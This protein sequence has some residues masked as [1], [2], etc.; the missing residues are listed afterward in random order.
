VGRHWGCDRC[1]WR[2][3][4]FDKISF[5]TDLLLD[6]IRDLEHSGP[7]GSPA[8]HKQLG[9]RLRVQR[10]R[11]KWPKPDSASTPPPAKPVAIMPEPQPQLED[12]LSRPE[13]ISV[14]NN[15]A[16]SAE[17]KAA[18]AAWA[19]LGSKASYRDVGNWIDHN[20][21]TPCRYA[22]RRFSSWES[23]L[24]K[25]SDD[26]QRRAC[27]QFLRRRKNKQWPMQ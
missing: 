7:F 26:S 19:A 20:R 22:P 6:L 24:A 9:L 13:L 15:D 3:E 4:D 18:D 27:E 1:G 8:Y 10:F 21:K 12:D 16:E 2:S 25:P 11:A 14:R 23:V 5:P 17:G